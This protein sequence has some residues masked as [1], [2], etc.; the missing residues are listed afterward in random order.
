M[1][2]IDPRKRILIL[3][4]LL[5]LGGI[6]AWYYTGF[7]RASGTSA[8][9]ASGTIEALDVA[10]APELPGRMAEVLVEK[11]QEVKAGA[12]VFRLDDAL[13]QAQRE[14]AAAALEAA[15]A[16]LAI[17]DTGIGNAEET[18]NSALASLDATRASAEAERLPVQQTLDDLNV[19]AGAA[20]GE[21]ARNVAAANRVLRDAVYLLDHYTV[22]SLQEDL[23]P[24]EGIIEMKKRLDDARVAFEPYRYTEKNSDWRD[25]LKDALDSAQSEYDRAVRRIELVSAVEAAEARLRKAEDDLSKLQDGPNPQD[26]AILEARLAAIGAVQKQAEAAVGLAQAGVETAKARLEAAQTAVRQAQAELDVMEVQIGKLTVFSPI[27]GVVLSRNVEPGEVVQPGAVVLAIGGLKQLKITVY[28]PEERYGEISL[29]QTAQV[30][31]D[32]F[33]GQVF[34]ATIVH[35]SD[36]A[37]FTPR[38]VQTIEGRRNTVFAIEMDIANVDGKLKPGMPADVSFEG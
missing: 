38:N 26:V 24:Q 35:I 17:A 21:A 18:L 25:D 19:N 1:H 5:T 8:L 37:E 36:Q 12:P 7:G 13:L 14:R 15:R 23:T 30:T 33:P 32:S 22:S 9:R 28:L 2:S 10:L 4:V 6:A 20:R 34:Q 11:G 27:D 31:V 16:N 3:L 29:G